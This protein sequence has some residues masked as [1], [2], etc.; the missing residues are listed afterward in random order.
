MTIKGR[1][2]FSIGEKDGKHIYKDEHHLPTDRCRGNET[3]G[4]FEEG[5]HD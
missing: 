1:R 5:R 2:K 4:G 3:P